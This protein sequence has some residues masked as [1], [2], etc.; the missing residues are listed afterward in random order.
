MVKLGVIIICLCYLDTCTAWNTFC[1]NGLR[2]LL[3]VAPVIIQSTQQ[4][5]KMPLDKIGWC[6][7]LR[8]VKSVGVLDVFYP[9]T[10]IVKIALVF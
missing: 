6:R 8:T 4:G 2:L 7:H 3:P 9:Y 5:I 10:I 1:F